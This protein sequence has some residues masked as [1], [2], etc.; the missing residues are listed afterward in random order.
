MLNQLSIC[1]LVATRKIGNVRREGALSA[2]LIYNF[3]I[4]RDTWVQPVAKPKGLVQS[5]YKCK[6]FQNQ[7]NVIL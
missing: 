5:I 3:S 6:N 2:P 4:Y 7:G 1:E